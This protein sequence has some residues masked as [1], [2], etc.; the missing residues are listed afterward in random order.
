M[1]ALVDEATFEAVQRKF[2]E[3]KRK[4]SQRA[5]GMGENGAP[6]YWLTGKLCCSKCGSPMQGVSGTSGTGRTYYSYYCAAQR[7][8]EC[9]MRKMRK[10]TLEDAVATVLGWI[11]NDSENLMSLAVDAG[12]VLREELPRHGL[13]GRPGGQAPRG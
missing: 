7:R 8:H 4:G 2:A 11:L 1:P 3:N 13:S 10:E 9:S 5:R 6:R 12:G